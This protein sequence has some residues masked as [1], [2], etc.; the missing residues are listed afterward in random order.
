M[1][2]PANFITVTCLRHT[3]PA[4]GLCGTSDLSNG[5]INNLPVTMVSPAES[6]RHHVG[7]GTRCPYANNATCVGICR[8]RTSRWTKKRENKITIPNHNRTT[9]E[10]HHSIVLVF[11][12]DKKKMKLTVP[13]DEITC[14]MTS[15]YPCHFALMLWRLSQRTGCQNRRTKNT[16]YINQPAGVWCNRPII[17]HCNG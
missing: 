2:L 15:Y 16:Q 13:V 12:N 8:E 17:I 9:I 3:F 5:V 10:Q 11:A 1:R 4:Q 6:G 7:L 14:G